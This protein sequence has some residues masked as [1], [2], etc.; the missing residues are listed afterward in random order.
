VDEETTADQVVRWALLLSL[1]APVGLIV[2]QIASGDA[3]WG[4]ALV[5]LAVG[6]ALF[7]LVLLSLW[8]KVKRD[9]PRR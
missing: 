9:G 3:S 8:G 1:A 5:L 4:R 7:P 6:A 2:A